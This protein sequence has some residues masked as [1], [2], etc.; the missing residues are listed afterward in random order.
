MSPFKLSYCF[1]TGLA[2]MWLLASAPLLQ[3]QLSKEEKKQLKQELKELAKNPEKFQTFKDGLQAKKEEV[4]RLNGEIDD[5]QSA[6]TTTQQQITEKDRKIKELGDELAR[7]K[8]EKEETQQVV[9]NQ[10]N[11]QGLVYKVQV[12]VNEASLYQ[13]I[14]QETG[15]KRPIFTGEQ[16]EDGSKKY[17][18]GYFKDKAEADTFCK[19]LQLL[20]IKEAKVVAY[21]DGKKVNP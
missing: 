2:L 17:T 14:S 11:L 20:R 18:L 15:E 16:D 3:A 19:Y 8:V 6:L 7:L 5:T 12:E 9:Q 1:T 21:R 10:T 13:E 4:M